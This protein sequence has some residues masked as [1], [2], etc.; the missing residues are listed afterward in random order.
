MTIPVHFAIKEK[1]TYKTIKS[2]F[3]QIDD[4]DEANV[5]KSDS[6]S[7]LQQSLMQIVKTVIKHYDP[8][9]D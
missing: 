4:F 5:F 8:E 9:V 2:L 7:V 1:S 3:K 6:L